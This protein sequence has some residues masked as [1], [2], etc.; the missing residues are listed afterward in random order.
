MSATDDKS[1]QTAT[2][3]SGSVQ[4][5]V[6]RRRWDGW[7]GLAILLLGFLHVWE[8][9]PT[10]IVLIPLGCWKLGRWA[11]S[12]NDQAERPERE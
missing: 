4:R 12:P 8:A 6:R 3:Q 2:A 9:M 10:A 5:L 1:T 7:M 11:A